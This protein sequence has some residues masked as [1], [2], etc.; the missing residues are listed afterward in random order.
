MKYIGNIKFAALSALALLSAA[1]ADENT[2]SVNEG[3]VVYP[4]LR[5]GVSEMTMEP[6]SRA[7]EP[8]GP[9]EEKYVRTLAIFEFDRE[10]VHTYSPTS[11]HFVDFTQGTVDGV[12]N[13]AVDSTE[14]GVVESSLGGL[15]FDSRDFGTICLVG[16]VTKAQVGELYQKCSE[17]GTTYGRVSFDQFKEWSLPFKYVDPPEG[18][19]YDET[20][21]G[22]VYPMYFFGYYQ[23][24]IVSSEADD[25]AVDLGRLAS[26][27][28][29]AFINETGG[30]I[31]EHIEYHFD[32]VCYNAYLFPIV[33]P[34]PN[35]LAPGQ[36]RTIVCTGG[37]TAIDGV[38]QTFPKDEDHLRYFYVAAHSAV[39]FKEATKL[40][41][42]Y[43]SEPQ[44]DDT[45]GPGG[46]DF[47]IPV[48]N[49]N[50]SDAA[51]VFNGYSLSR[52]TRYRFNIRLR[53]RGHSEQAEQSEPASRTESS[54]IPGEVIVY[55]P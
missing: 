55:L 22:H 34:R 29:V 1:C 43:G 37:M 52:N 18:V 11:F 10:E 25:I 35:N 15:A 39:D 49:I 48:C 12:K 27:I 21:L 16:N 47:K 19:D 46:V 53:K 8:M 14:Y 50:P 13:A 5:F 36:S 40:H 24:K 17:T 45:P 42:F 20:V 41:L 32:E 3:E 54:E 7:T 9:D 26:R 6:V 4:R 44:A 31:T 28:D 51:S 30:D 33:S 38:Q 23:G 2:P